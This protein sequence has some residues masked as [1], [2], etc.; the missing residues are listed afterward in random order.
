M[1]LLHQKFVKFVN[2]NKKNLGK[3]E[4]LMN[5]KN[6]LIGTTARDSTIIYVIVCSH[7]LNENKLVNC[8]DV[9]EHI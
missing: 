6:L 7:A 1:L 5:K 4:E 8:N 3:N 2:F 9:E